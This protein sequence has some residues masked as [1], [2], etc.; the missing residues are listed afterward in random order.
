[1]KTREKLDSEG[2]SGVRII[3]SGGFCPEKISEFVKREIPVDAYGVGSCLLQGNYDFTADVVK[4]NG[5]L[6]SKKGRKYN[7][8]PRLR[9]VKY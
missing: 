8:N 2:F 1:M 9:S 3:V 4:I 6:C 5:R 7:E